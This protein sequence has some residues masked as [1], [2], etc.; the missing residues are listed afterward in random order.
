V[1]DLVLCIHCMG[2]K[3]DPRNDDEKP[4]YLC[5]GAGWTAEVLKQKTIDNAEAF[6]HP[7]AFSF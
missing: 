1:N 4:C 5:G 6:G 7:P 2:S 3:A